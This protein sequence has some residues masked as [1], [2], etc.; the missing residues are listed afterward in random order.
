MRE[1]SFH[2]PKVYENQNRGTANDAGLVSH[3]ASALSLASVSGDPICVVARTLD[4][5]PRPTVLC[6]MV[7]GL[8]KGG[9]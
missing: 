2:K 3:L 6:L 1:D 8:T 7:N 5:D 4:S 9:I